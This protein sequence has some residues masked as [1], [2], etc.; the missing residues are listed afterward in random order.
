MS[1]LARGSGL[2]QMRAS[3]SASL[4]LLSAHEPIEP[5][6]DDLV[7]LLV[8]GLGGRS[9]TFFF[10][11]LLFPYT[12][13]DYFRLR[14]FACPLVFLPPPFELSLLPHRSCSGGK[15]VWI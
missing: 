12:Y 10:R 15:H 14:S 3:I 7:S 2:A 9:E 6:D 4:G 5:Y 11:L 13:T 8:S 1:G